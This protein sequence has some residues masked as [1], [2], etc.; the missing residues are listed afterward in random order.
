MVL[1][2]PPQLETKLLLLSISV[3]LN[4]YMAA[5][6]GMTIDSQTDVLYTLCFESCFPPLM[7]SH[8]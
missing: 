8:T 5:V 4:D 7:S 2:D 3:L 1:P 6:L